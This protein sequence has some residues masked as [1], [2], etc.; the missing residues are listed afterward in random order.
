MLFLTPFRGDHVSAKLAAGIIF[1]SF[2]EAM[3]DH[4]ELV[5][6]ISARWFRKTTLFAA[7]NAAVACDGTFIHIPKGVRCPMELSTYFL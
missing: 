3:H 7:L 5:K 1:C 6:A 2:G 4:A